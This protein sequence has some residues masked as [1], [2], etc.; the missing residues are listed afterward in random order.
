MGLG[1]PG[2]PP[3][4]SRRVQAEHAPRRTFLAYGGYWEDKRGVHNDND[5]CQN[6]L[7][8]GRPQAAS[9][10]V[11]HQVRLPI[12]ARDRRLTWRRAGS[13]S[14]TGSTSSTEGPRRR[15]SWEVKATARTVASG[16]RARL[17]IEPRA[18][19]EFTLPL[20]KIEP[21]A[22]RGVLLNV[23]FRLKQATRWAPVGHEIAWDQFA[24]PGHR[25]RSRRIPSQGTLR[26]S[27]TSARRPLTGQDFRAAL[28][29]AERAR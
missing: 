27:R 20:P 9:R 18:E 1:G 14:R 5:F 3:A 24:L 26:M 13:G 19:K 28:R 22:R 21:A 29:Q 4:G 12:P 25:G 7:V 23:S 17:D 16:Q 2:H 11:R 6:G 10:A 8:G 15:A